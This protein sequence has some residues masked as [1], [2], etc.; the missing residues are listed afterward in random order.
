ME[1]EDSE[2]E[3]EEEEEEE[4]E[5]EDM[6]DEVA[7]EEDMKALN[8]I[9]N[10]QDMATEDI[11]TES[12]ELETAETQSQSRNVTSHQTDD[13]IGMNTDDGEEKKHDQ[14]VVDKVKSKESDGGDE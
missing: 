12:I 9:G 3:E 5:N 4:S 2:N 7:L 6:L 14:D 11:N 1:E 8:L 13:M 10:E